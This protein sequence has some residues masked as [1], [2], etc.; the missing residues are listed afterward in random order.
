MNLEIQFLR[1]C[2]I[3]NPHN[4]KLYWRLRL[5]EHFKNRA[6]QRTWNA[7]YAGQEAGVANRYRHVN[8]RIDGVT[9]YFTVHRLSWALQTGAWPKDEVDHKNQNKDDNRWV[10][11]REATHVENMRNRKTGRVCKSGHRGVYVLPSGRFNVRLKVEAKR[12]NAGTFD[13]YEDA[14]AAYRR[15]AQ[16]YFGEFCVFD[17]KEPIS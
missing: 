8:I 15:L 3:Y 12:I 11:L 6:N 14:C 13:F 5:L 1:E 16:H 4:G 9:R 2:F 17:M 7:R 10:N